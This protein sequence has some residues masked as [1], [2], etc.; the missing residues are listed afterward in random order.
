MDE[1]EQRLQESYS[2]QRYTVLRQFLADHEIYALEAR[3]S[4]DAGALACCRALLDLPWR[5]SLA[6][7]RLALR[8]R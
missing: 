1:G 7:T 5:M 2:A 4:G 6:T 3:L 8:E